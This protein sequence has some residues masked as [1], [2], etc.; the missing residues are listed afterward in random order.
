MKI[1]ISMKTPDCIDNA[2]HE[3][4]ISDREVDD[5]RRISKKFFRYDE[6]VELEIDTET[7]TCIV[8]PKG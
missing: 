4:A 6:C 5:I 1:R 3:L 8:V 7:E 2:M